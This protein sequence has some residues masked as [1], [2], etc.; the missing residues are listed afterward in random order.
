MGGVK[1]KLEQGLQ[2]YI[3]NITNKNSEEA[4]KQY[5]ISTLFEEIFGVASEDLDFEV[6]TKT[7]SQ[8]RGRADTLFQN[9]IFEWK[10]DTKNSKAIDDGEIELKKYFQHYLEK[11]PLKKY[12]GIITDGIIFKPYLPIIKK[13]EVTDLSVTN[14]LDI[15]KALPEEILYWFDNYLH[16]A[17]KIKPTSK[18]I[19]MQ[20]GLSSPYFMDVRNELNN[21]FEKVRDYK[22]VKLKFDNWSDYLEIVYGEKQKGKDLFFRHTYLSTLVKLLVHLKLSYNESMR[23]DEILPILFGNRFTQAGIMNFSEEDFFTWPLSISIRKKSSQIFS[24]LLVELERYDID[25]IDED[26]L[27]ELYQELVSPEVRK[28]LGEFYTPD[29]LAEK[30]VIETLEDNPLKSVLDPACGSG[31]FLFKTIQFKIKKLTKKGMKKTDILKHITENVFGFDVHPLAAIISKTNYLLSL[32]ELLAD[33]R[34]EITIPVFLSDSLKIPE[35]RNDVSSGL[36]VLE[37]EAVDKKFFFPENIAS[38]MLK[39]DG[40]INNLKTHGSALYQNLEQARSNNY[41]TSED[42]INSNLLSSYE[43]SIKDIQDSNV[44]R[45]LLENA[46]ILFELIRNDLDSIWPYILRNMYRPISL[47]YKKVDLIIG[48]PPWISLKDMKNHTYQNFLKIENKNFGLSNSKKPHLTTQM[49]LATLFFCKSVKSYLNKKGMIAFVM[50]YSIL[51][52]EQHKKFLGFS[53]PEIKIH[54]IYDLENV[55]PLFRNLSCI[56]IGETIGKTKYPIPKIMVKGKLEKGNLQLNDVEQ[57][58]SSEKINFNPF[59]ND[60]IKRSVYDEKFYEG[61]NIYPRNFFSVIPELT[62]GG[63]NIQRPKVTSNPSNDTKPPWSDVKISQE[64]EKSFYLLV[65]LGGMFY[66]LGI[67]IID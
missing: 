30:M 48:N 28:Q 65:F 7:V 45:V 36:K 42:E 18:S 63:M 24:K 43:V 17:E 2:K 6:P 55:R 31:T 14:E 1:E 57:H 5:C 27:K 11:E 50:P 9:I 23:M 59:K 13:D 10:R 26:V 4:K 35:M 51:V 29:W 61:A 19:K 54:K 41:T 67:V 25:A 12:V 15:S 46:K 16:N 62:L 20:F 52:G 33:R 38:D 53:N 8:L 47:S 49:E 3:H 60:N 66:H 32:R 39:M 58:L 37:F 44:K 64:I 21:L 40:V 34:E 22:D 56:I